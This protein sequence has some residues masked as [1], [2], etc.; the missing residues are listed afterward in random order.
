MMCEF[1]TPR[2]AR[3]RDHH[4]NTIEDAAAWEHEMAEQ[5]DYNEED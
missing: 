3:A 1:C 2:P 5:Y 4:T